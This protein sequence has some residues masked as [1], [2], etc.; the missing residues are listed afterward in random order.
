MELASDPATAQAGPDQRSCEAELMRSAAALPTA[1][2]INQGW[3]SVKVREEPDW[4]R[5]VKKS[6]QAIPVHSVATPGERPA[7]A[8]EL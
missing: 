2:R 1:S 5:L 7:K 8:G 3:V 6:T 4:L